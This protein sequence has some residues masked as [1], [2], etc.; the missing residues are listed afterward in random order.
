MLC[1]GC[2]AFTK[3]RRFSPHNILF[4]NSQHPTHNKPSRGELNKILEK[5]FGCPIGQNVG[6]DQVRT[7]TFTCTQ[8]KKKKNSKRNTRSPRTTGTGDTIY[9]TQ[10]I[11]VGGKPRLVMY[12]R[13]PNTNLILGKIVQ[14]GKMQII[15]DKP[16]MM[17]VANVDLKL[18]VI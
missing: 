8:T 15:S 3:G 1:T 18:R 2:V 6:T 17:T 4:C 5:Y 9:L 13:G 16:K 10:W 11:R 7:G 14:E 12:D